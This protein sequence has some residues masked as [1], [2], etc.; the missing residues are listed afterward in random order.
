MFN[1]DLERAVKDTF[2]EIVQTYNFVLVPADDTKVCLFNSRFGLMLYISYDGVNISYITKKDNGEYVIYWL[3]FFLNKKFDEIDREQYGKTATINE[4]YYAS[5]RVLASGLQR[6]W[7]NI[8]EGDKSWIQDYLDQGYDEE[9]LNAPT[10][11]FV[12][13]YF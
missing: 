2:S 5:F 10:L 7:S 6:H 12:K 4:D 1:F 13:K 9:V 11:D 3:M 8:L